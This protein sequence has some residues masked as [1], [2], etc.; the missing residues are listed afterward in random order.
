MSTI[1]YVSVSDA[2]IKTEGVCF[3]LPYLRSTGTRTDAIAD[4]FLGGDSVEALARDFGA[5][6]S[7]IEL[8]IRFEVKDR[9][10]EL[11]KSL[12]KQR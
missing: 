10:R 9:I 12:E 5:S 1:L 2:V 8:A 4:R 3:G 6:T 11:A 7:S